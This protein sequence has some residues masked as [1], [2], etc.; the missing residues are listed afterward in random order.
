MTNQ[1]F[2]YNQETQQRNEN[3]AILLYNVRFQKHKTVPILILREKADPK[4]QYQLSYTPRLP[5]K[6]F[7]SQQFR[8][9][10]TASFIIKDGV[11][12][13]EN[14]RSQ[15]EINQYAIRNFQY[16]PIRYQLV[17]APRTFNNAAQ[18]SSS[19]NNYSFYLLENLAFPIRRNINGSTET[20]DAILKEF[21][22][23]FYSVQKVLS[24][25]SISANTNLDNYSLLLSQS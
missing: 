22:V 14:L 21:V 13:F 18:N 4:I 3:L 11:L 20:F 10:N 1:E 6:V 24:I 15:Y 7:F 8:V 5:K 25:Q 23:N 17:G 16:I 2:I 19:F 9:N 12:S